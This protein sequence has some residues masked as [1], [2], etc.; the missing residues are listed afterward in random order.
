MSVRV[1]ITSDN[2]MSE[3]DRGDVMSSAASSQLPPPPVQN[4]ENDDAIPEAFTEPP[5]GQRSWFGRKKK[6]QTDEKTALL[7]VS[8]SMNKSKTSSE[9]LKLIMDYIQRTCLNKAILKARMKSFLS[10]IDMASLQS[11]RTQCCCCAVG[12]F[13]A[14]FGIFMLSAGICIVLNV[15][16]ME[17][18]TS[19]LPPELHNDDGKKVVGIILICVAI[20]ALG[21]SASVSVVYFVICN[22]KDDNRQ[23]SQQR[24]QQQ[25]GQQN[26]IAPHHRH[27]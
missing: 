26:S 21:L 15:T 10:K 1:R 23:G 25:G 19:G 13:A 12:V 22:R 9:Y 3:D 14:M 5:R 8:T 18:D 16:F 24:Q 11:P 4:P 17:V 2:D 6:V 7:P 27:H 20:A